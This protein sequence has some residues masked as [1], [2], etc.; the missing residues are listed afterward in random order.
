MTDLGRLWLLRDALQK[1]SMKEL[2]QESARC[3]L[4]TGLKHDQL[5]ALFNIVTDIQDLGRSVS[6]SVS[7]ERI[8]TK[9]ATTYLSR[10]DL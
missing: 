6:Y 5:F 7:W 9:L 10:G 4:E 3:W 1:L 2:L 8:Y